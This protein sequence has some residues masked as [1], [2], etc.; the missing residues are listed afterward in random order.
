LNFPTILTLVRLI[1]SPVV[2]PVLLVYLL[3]LNVIFING[4]LAGLFVVL[5][6]TDFFDGYLA[7]RM[8]V[9]T[10]LGRILDPIADK[11][12]FYSTLISLLAAGKLFFAWPLIFIGREF[13][14]M[15]LRIVAL[16]HAFSVPVSWLGKF[17]SFVMMVYLAVVIANPY[18]E[19]GFTS[20]RFNMLE[21]LL[22]LFSLLLSLG[23]AREYFRSFLA[24]YKK[25][26]ESTHGV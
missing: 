24:S 21:L 4:A 15:S 10:M 25:S 22:L 8:D 1:V 3:P 11:F 26:S 7:R 23:S 20:S 14:I 6:L 18:Q 13:F 16:E 12:L 17:K 5:S 9:E 19:L 2:L